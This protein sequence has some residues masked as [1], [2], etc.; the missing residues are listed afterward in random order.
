MK[1]IGKYSLSFILL[2]IGF[3]IFQIDVK[4]KEQGLYCQYGDYYFIYS[5][6]E[7]SGKFEFDTNFD[8][9]LGYSIEIDRPSGGI[10][11]SEQEQAWLREKG[12][13]SGNE[14]SC[15]SNPFGLE[16]GN[17]TEKE[18]LSGNCSVSKVPSANESYTC[19]YVQSS[20]DKTIQI[21]YEST[22]D[23]V[24][25]NVTYPDG[26][27]KEFI[28]SEI[29]GNFMP[30]KDCEDIYYIATDN[31]ISTASISTSDLCN[32]YGKR[33]ELYCA[34]GRECHYE[35]PVCSTVCDLKDIPESLPIY[36]SNIINLIKIIVPIVLVLMGM[37]DFA[38]AV[39]SS[40]EKQM[41]E[42][43]SRFIRRIM[44]A[45]FIF[46]IVAVVQFVFGIIKTDGSLAGCIN[47]FVNGDC[48]WT[49][50]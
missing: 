16:I 48:N 24:K 20:G 22:K 10:F 14:F 23:M 15:P 30:G 27:T 44:A 2:I 6:I 21:K 7:T 39:M 50:R 1:Q 26:S 4:A 49:T 36:I 41:K 42:S 18:C 35:P 40:D 37:I 25:W 45:I 13:I 32:K 43:Q 3:L 47:C 31:K 38:R 9:E 8:S 33:I 11:S 5:G 17:P 19:K 29:N 12:L 28:N 34:S 46:L